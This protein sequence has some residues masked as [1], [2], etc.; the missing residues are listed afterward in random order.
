MREFIVVG[1]NKR[2]QEKVKTRNNNWKQANPDYHKQWLSRHPGYITRYFKRRKSIDLAF[3][4]RCELQCLLYMSLKTKNSIG[5]KAA[6]AVGCSIPELKNKLALLFVP[7]MSWDNYGKVWEIDHKTPASK[8]DHSNPEEV[9]KCWHFTNLQPLFIKD[10][11]QKSST[12]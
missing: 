8:F 11:L 6:Q 7:P 4:L 3:K 12:C 9:K 2:H 5:G 10:N 1:L